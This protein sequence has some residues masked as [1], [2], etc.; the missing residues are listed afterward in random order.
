VSFLAAIGISIINEVDFENLISDK[1][2]LKVNLTAKLLIKKT[3]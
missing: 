2:Y 1:G 3:N